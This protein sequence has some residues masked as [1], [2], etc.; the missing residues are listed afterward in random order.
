MGRWAFAM[1]S[2]A[3]AIVACSSFGAEEEGRDA[4]ADGG[5]ADAAVDGRTDGASASDAGACG[6]VCDEG[7]KGICESFGFQSCPADL[8]VGGD[9]GGIVCRDGVMRIDASGSL[10]AT[11]SL[12]FTPRLS[13]RV[14]VHFAANVVEW[15]DFGGKGA[16]RLV[17]V[18]S[19][20][21]VLA[22]VRAST[23]TDRVVLELC[24]PTGACTTAS[25]DYA[26]KQTF[27]LS[28]VVEPK[29]GA[30]L[31]LDCAEAASTATASGAVI[32]KRLEVAFGDVDGDPMRATIGALTV[33]LEPG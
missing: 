12:D 23:R 14:H 10:D 22:T 27:Q 8:A 5:P 7:R 19:D 20:G 24:T 4:G 6:L 32:D 16:R 17:D 26:K 18:K 2:W 9:D 3:A 15:I 25:R 21:K 1:L 28:L 33:W 30:K 13:S 11:A 29:G 31:L